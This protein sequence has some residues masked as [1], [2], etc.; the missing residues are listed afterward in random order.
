MTPSDRDPFD[1]L[2]RLPDPEPDPEVMRKA[3]AASREA[4]AQQRAGK[5]QLQSRGWR[6]R[7]REA[8]ARP[9]AWLVPAGAGAFAVVIAI[10]VL[11]GVL[12]QP[13]LFDGATQR[14]AAPAEA[15]MERE[16]PAMAE[17]QP[18]P[19]APEPEGADR[20]S[21]APPPAPAPAAAPALADAVPAEME[22]YAEDGIRLGYRIGDGRYSLFLLSGAG[23][24]A[25]DERALGAESI[26]I[27]DALRMRRPGEPEI[28]AV[29]TRTDAG[30]P[31]W[32]A[33]VFTG[34]DI[35]RDA[36]LSA[37]IADAADAR[38]V[39]ARLDAFGASR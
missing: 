30:A 6:A 25:M 10:G 15:L 33:Y 24:L 21:A 2:R 5:R 3:I 20:F 12:T 23:D 39:K 9:S 13:A 31:A 17:A 16:A 14:Q 1:A 22:I 19:V 7:I 38:E 26:E 34:M 8:F 29:R 4:F 37:L 32:D 28:I 36:Q 18:A 27:I 35:D 11:P